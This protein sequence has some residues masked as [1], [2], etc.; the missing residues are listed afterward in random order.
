MSR[1]FAGMAGDFTQFLKI[2]KNEIINCTNTCGYSINFEIPVKGHS[3]KS[4][5]L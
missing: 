1:I 4:A 3:N 5:G 2:T